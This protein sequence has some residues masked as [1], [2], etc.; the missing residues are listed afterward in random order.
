[1]S[2]Y[3]KEFFPSNTGECRIAVHCWKPEGEIKGV[4]QFVHGM[5][6]YVCRFEHVAKYLN[7]L[8]YVFCG[9]D[10]AGHG[11]SIPDEAHKGFF[12]DEDGWD[13]LVADIMQL[14]KKLKEEYPGVKHILYG[15]SMG[16]FLSRTCAARFPDEFD[17]F[18][19]SGTAGKNPAMPLAKFIAEMEIKRRGGRGLSPL[20]NSL[21]FGPYAKS[22]KNARTEFDWLSTDES[23]VDKYVADPL[24]GFN[25]K[26]AAYR[27]MFKGLMEISTKKWLKAV[28]NV[29][30]YIFSGAKDPV[31]SMGKGPRKLCDKLRKNGKTQVRL[32][33][34]ENGR[35]EM[36]NETNKDEVLKGIAAFLKSI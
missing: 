7:D 11:E 28:P 23:V 27:D 34:Y 22:V 29:P 19:W 17:A 18:I 31:G 4:V 14:H 24:C 30:I 3:R 10:H 12:A 8:G 25:F 32:Q 5:S 26:C 20:L 15:H 16:S 36:H 13:K 35:H 33:L 2:E 6:E 9:E 1:M 21:V